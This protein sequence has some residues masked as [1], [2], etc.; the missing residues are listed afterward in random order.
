[1]VLF[2]I[3]SFL[4][5]LLTKHCLYYMRHVWD[6]SEKIDGLGP[7]SMEKW[8]NIKNYLAEFPNFLTRNARAVRV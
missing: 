2:T 3:N 7:V 6:V 4:F 1:M 8:Y 5:A